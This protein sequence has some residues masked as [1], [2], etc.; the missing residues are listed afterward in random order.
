MTNEDN[1]KLFRR[2]R[3]CEKNRRK[4]DAIRIRQE[5]AVGNIGLVYHYAHRYNW[6]ELAGL[7]EIDDLVSAGVIGMYKAI[8]RFD[9]DKGFTFSTYGRFWIRTYIDEE[10]RKVSTVKAPKKQWM[11]SGSMV[12]LDE[13]IKGH[14]DRYDVIEANMERPEEV[15]VER[16]EKRIYDRARTVVDLRLGYR[17]AR[18]A[19]LRID[20]EKTYKDIGQELGVT[21]QRVH[22]MGEK[23]LRE[24]KSQLEQGY[25]T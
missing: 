21:R 4:K 8:D 13:P 2:L 24:L 25:I 16:E 7:I 14:T 6:M 12:S 17:E 10:T 5:I 15:C 20:E 23:Y 19:K 18:V 1:Q 3:R 11:P 9:A 22:Q